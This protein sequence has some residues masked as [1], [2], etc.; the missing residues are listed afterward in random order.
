MAHLERSI[1]MGPFC[2]FLEFMD[3]WLDCVDSVFAHR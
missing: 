2:N 1:H 3:L